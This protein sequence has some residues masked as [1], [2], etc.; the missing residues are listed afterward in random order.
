MSRF[1]EYY[2]LS[3]C[4]LLVGWV[5]VCAEN[6]IL[7]NLVESGA[8]V[9]SCLGLYVQR[10]EYCMRSAWLLAGPCITSLPLPHPGSMIIPCPSPRHVHTIGDLLAL[11]NFFIPAWKDD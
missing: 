5:R 8:G 1:H 7:I 11:M 10:I 4:S 9:V 3:L 6:R 2:W